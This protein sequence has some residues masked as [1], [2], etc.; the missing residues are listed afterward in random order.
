MA[1][2]RYRSLGVPVTV[3]I[4]S[5]FYLISYRQF[6][7]PSSP[8]PLPS[9]SLP[10]HNIGS[11]VAKV[12]AVIVSCVGTLQTPAIASQPRKWC[13][14]DIWD[15][16]ELT[17]SWHPLV[18]WYFWDSTWT[19]VPA[20]PSH[21]SHISKSSGLINDCGENNQPLVVFL[22][23]KPGGGELTASSPWP[24][25]TLPLQTHKED[26]GAVGWINLG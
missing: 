5:S 26:A 10:G 13:E 3:I 20:Q 11:V 17:E 8:L 2:L 12:R 6:I 9:P 14:N 23:D 7:Q 22:L 25:P 24:H 19:I 16:W 4:F 15:D 18:G 1:V 21:I